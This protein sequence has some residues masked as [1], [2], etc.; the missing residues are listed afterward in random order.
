MHAVEFS[1]AGWL[2]HAAWA[3]HRGERLIVYSRPSEVER[4]VNARR[5][6]NRVER[7]LLSLLPAQA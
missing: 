3:A 1:P 7:M 5:N 2:E 6:E 4:R